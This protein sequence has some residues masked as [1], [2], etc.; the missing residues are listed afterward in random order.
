M[1]SLEYFLKLLLIIFYQTRFQMKRVFNGY[2]SLKHFNK[3]RKQW[4]N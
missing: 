3:S 4:G 1:Q 2:Y